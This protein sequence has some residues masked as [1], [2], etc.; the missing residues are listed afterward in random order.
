MQAVA[1]RSLTAGGGLVLEA[2]FT[3]ERSEAWLRGLAEQAETRVLICR[4]PLDR[5]RFA[6]RAGKRHAVHPDDLAA[7]WPAAE[8]FAID[9]GVPRLEVDTTDGY[10][11]DLDTIMRFIA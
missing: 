4:T 11:P 6:A 8:T 1:A 2:N 5:E 9:I 3:R 7:E 10:V